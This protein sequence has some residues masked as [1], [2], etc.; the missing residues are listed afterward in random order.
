MSNNANIVQVAQHCGWCVDKSGNMVGHVSAEI[1]EK[2]ANP[3]KF[4]GGMRGAENGKP[5][6]ER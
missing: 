4:Q 6:Y 1:W 2:L 5:V 3:L